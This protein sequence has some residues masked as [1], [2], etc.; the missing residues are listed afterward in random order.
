VLY[1]E[2]YTVVPRN[3]AGTWK[4]THGGA[5]WLVQHV[6]LIMSGPG[7]RSGVYSAF[8]AR[9]IDIAP[10]MEQLLGLPPI[11]RD[12]VALA[13]ALASPPKAEVAAQN[14][15]YPTLATEVHALQVQSAADSHHSPE[16]PTPPKAKNLCPVVSSTGFR[17]CQTSA[18]TATNE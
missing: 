3:V 10:T 17:R 1:R 18:A 11:K 7:I 14:Q 4:G 13:D 16:W 6:P 12:G 2:N 8:P 5:T 15:I 9:A